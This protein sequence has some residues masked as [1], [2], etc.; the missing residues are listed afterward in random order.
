MSEN[1]KINFKMQA[2][3]KNHIRLRDLGVRRQEL[4]NSVCVSGG[5]GGK[6]GTGVEGADV[7]EVGGF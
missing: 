7:D 5:E 1:L 2:L 3:P 4:D 6:K